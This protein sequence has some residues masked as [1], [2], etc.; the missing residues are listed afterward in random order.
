MNWPRSPGRFAPGNSGKLRTDGIS[1]PRLP[2]IPKSRRDPEFLD[3]I[4]LFI[5]EEQRHGE[6]LGRFLDLA[7]VA[8]AS[9]DLGDALFRGFRYLFPRMEVWATVVVMVETH[10]MLYYAAVRRATRSGVLRSICRQ[11]LRDEPPHIRFQCERLA[12]LHHRRCRLF[13]FLTMAC[14]RVFFFGITLAIWLLHRRGAA[15]GRVQVRPLLEVRVVED[16]P[17]VADDAPAC[18]PLAGR[19]GAGAADRVVSGLTR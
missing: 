16:G 4:R 1:W 7:G 5:A 15:G 17:R 6:E 10:A 11:I 9:W 18:V 19:G 2:T 3:A 13:H 12:I 8:R 14:H